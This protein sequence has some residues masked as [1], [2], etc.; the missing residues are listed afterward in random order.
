[1]N[2]KMKIRARHVL[3]FRKGGQTTTNTGKILKF[4]GKVSVRKMITHYV[5]RTEDGEEIHYKMNVFPH[6][7]PM[8]LPQYKRD[9]LGSINILTY[10]FLLQQLREI[11]KLRVVDTSLFRKAA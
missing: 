8:N 4:V 10:D 2:S 7:A 9:S 1:M 3:A 6:L 5:F 11:K